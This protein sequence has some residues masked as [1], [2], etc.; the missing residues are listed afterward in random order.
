MNNY[1]S[2]ILP[3]HNP[4]ESRFNQTLLGL[5]N[6]TLQFQYWELIVIDNNSNNIIT[7]D[8]SWHPNA[9][10]TREENTGLTYARLKGFKEALG[11]III[12]VDD[13]NIL[14]PDYL[15]RTIL[16][17]T[18]YPK[19]GAIGGKSFPNFE[20]TPPIWLE[21]FYGNL[22]L[23]DL[24]DDII[25]AEWTNKYPD[26]APIG[27]GMAI[28]KEALK[29]YVKK[30]NSEK[31]IIH[32]RKGNSL[33]SGGDNDIVLE[34]LKGGWKVGYFPE[35]ILNH[36]IPKERTETKYLGRLLNN[37]NKSWIKLL[38]NHGIN[39]WNRIPKW[40]VPFRKF[41][42]WFT[43]SAWKNPVNYIKWQGA[44]G[45]FDGLAK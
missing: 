22:A 40:T 14:Q 10:I 41:K 29:N 44:C 17:F 3:T 20:I 7:T 5:K 11:N 33:S 43:Y 38:D 27:A 21:N 26:S 24:G 6:Q 18:Q 19:L 25:I 36:I 45:I 13:D 9:Q 2:V 39:P 37:S 42:S 4:N 16:L 35:L 34:I 15:E 31:N 8:L 1:L 30:I 23:R 28:R 12:M 32:D